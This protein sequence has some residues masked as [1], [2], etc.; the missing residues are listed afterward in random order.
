MMGFSLFGILAVILEVI[1]PFLY[2]IALLVGVWIIALLV[3]AKRSGVKVSPENR[4]ISVIT[5]L[6]V[7]VFALLFV[8]AFTGASHGNLHSVIDYAALFG[9][10][11]GA[12]IA[13]ALFVVPFLQ[14]FRT[15]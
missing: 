15:K 8:P 5:G 4:K 14:V 11:V 12:G 2:L 10:A 3:M 13:V 1:R 6:V 7:F 9:M